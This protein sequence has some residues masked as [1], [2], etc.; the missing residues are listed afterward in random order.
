MVG[1]ECFKCSIVELW[2]H[3]IKYSE[4]KLLRKPFT[5]DLL[6]ELTEFKSSNIEIQDILSLIEDILQ[7]CGNNNIEDYK[8][9]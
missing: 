3:I 9:N 4:I 2:D 7:L 6:A 8:T 5:E 1:S